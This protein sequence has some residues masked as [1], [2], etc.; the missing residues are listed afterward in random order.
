MKTIIECLT[1]ARKA[2][3][4]VNPWPWERV[5]P[6]V[7]DYKRLMVELQT[8]VDAHVAQGEDLAALR[9]QEAERAR[10]VAEG[11]QVHST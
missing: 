3:A 1:Q 5:M 7:C 9:A 4:P 6:S 10:L 8:L 2:Q 11:L